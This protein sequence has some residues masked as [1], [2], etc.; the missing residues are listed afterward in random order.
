MADVFLWGS[1]DQ[2]NFGDDLMAVLIG[3]Y[4]LDHGHS[5]TI[6]GEGWSEN[7]NRKFRSS[8]EVFDAVGRA[9]M[10]IIGG[11]EFL[12]RDNL[13]RRL[14]RRH[15]RKFEAQCIDFLNA[16]EA[17][18]KK[19]FAVSVGGDGTADGRR[20]SPSRRRLFSSQFCVGGTVRLKGDLLLS[21]NIGFSVKYYPDILLSTPV[22]YRTGF[23]SP[24]D[25]IT[26]GVNLSVN[27]YRK[28]RGIL[29]RLANKETS[30]H[31][32]FILSHTIKSGHDY[33]IQGDPALPRSSSVQYSEVGRFIDELAHLD[34]IVSSKLH[35]G[36][37]SAAYDATFI[38]YQG[39]PK[40]NLFVREMA[41][42]NNPEGATNCLH[43]ATEEGLAQVLYREISRRKKEGGF[44]RHRAPG[45]F[46]RESLK[47]FSE[48][49][50]V[51]NEVP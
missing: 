25:Q 7:V 10:C 43:V 27:S 19:F 35:V 6:F 33:E 24:S 3:T 44:G 40:A 34:I 38:S 30:L 11:G 16:C 5:V 14:I 51:V 48:L 21:R 1:Y 39:K 28:V 31:V 41:A 22:F 46:L 26:V 42:A 12:F 45:V 37:V 29:H 47:H 9:D 2:G 20:L 13:I 15:P 49:L 17:H 32:R 50:D 36:L 4:L 23:D 8:S 18:G